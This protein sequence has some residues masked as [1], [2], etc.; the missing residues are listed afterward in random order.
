MI[1]RKKRIETILNSSFSN[2][3]IKV[4]DNSARHKGHNNF[5][6]NQE[7]HF[8]IVLKSPNK[9]SESKIVIHR[10]INDLLR[11]E[12]QTGLHALEI[13]IIN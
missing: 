3:Q 11:K 12:Y 9:L 5:D 10:K 4:S 13:K 2:Y 1:K 8:L 7:S 6:G